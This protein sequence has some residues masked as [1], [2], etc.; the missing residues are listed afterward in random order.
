MGEGDDVVDIVH[1][2]LVDAALEC[3]TFG[4]RQRVGHVGQAEEHTPGVGEALMHPFPVAF[5]GDGTFPFA[6]EIGFGLGGEHFLCPEEQL[7]R[8]LLV[9]VQDT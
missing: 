3:G 4:Y 2:E 6:I 7:G 5:M 8:E 1:G 9:F